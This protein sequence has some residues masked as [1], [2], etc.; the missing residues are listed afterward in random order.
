MRLNEGNAMD[1]IKIIV[2]ACAVV[3]FLSVT[4]CVSIHNENQGAPVKEESTMTSAPPVLLAAPGQAEYPVQPESKAKTVVL[5]QM[6][7][8]DAA[9]GPVDILKDTKKPCSA[10]ADDAARFKK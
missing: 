10:V 2:P 5:E 9:S 6:Q 1:M 3:G 8:P 7:A 4:G